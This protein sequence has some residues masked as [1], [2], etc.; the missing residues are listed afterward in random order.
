MEVILDTDASGV[1]AADIGEDIFT[2]L[3]MERAATIGHTE[4]A[5]AVVFWLEAGIFLLCRVIDDTHTAIKAI[6]EV[7]WAIDTE[8]VEVVLHR[9]GNRPTDAAG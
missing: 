1:Q 6:T 3:C 4:W 5:I 7:L 9:D 8:E 2:E